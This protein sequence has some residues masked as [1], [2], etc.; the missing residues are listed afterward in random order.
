MRSVN[1]MQ[2]SGTTL[3]LAFAAAAFGENEIAR[4]LALMSVAYG[5]LET[6]VRP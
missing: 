4:Y 5:L 6:L 2:V 3:A 1:W